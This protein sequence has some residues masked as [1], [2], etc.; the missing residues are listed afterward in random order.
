MDITLKRIAM[1]DCGTFG[2]LIT[3][4]IPFALTLEREW[5]NNQQNVSCIPSGTYVCKR[6]WSPKFGG[7]FEVMTVPERSHIL[8]HKGNLEDDSHGCIL[9][10]EQ[11]ESLNGVP[12]ILA[13][14]K[15]YSEFIGKLKDKNNF[16]LII[17]EGVCS[18]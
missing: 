2:V 11:Y 17:E 18:G 3:D 7:T 10:G 5:K 16:Q 15:G 6:I 13:S 4:G 9:I 1:A 8:F 12:G 14:R